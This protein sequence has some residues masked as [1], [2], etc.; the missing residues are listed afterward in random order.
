MIINNKT[1]KWW[2]WTVLWSR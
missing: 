1:N 2:F